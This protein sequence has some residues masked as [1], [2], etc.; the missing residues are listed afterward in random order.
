MHMLLS[1]LSLLLPDLSPSPISGEAGSPFRSIPGSYLTLSNTHH[2]NKVIQ[3]LRMA[4]K[5]SE[6]T[7]LQISK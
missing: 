2:R 4:Q 6:R 1:P 5:I 7:I 3:T